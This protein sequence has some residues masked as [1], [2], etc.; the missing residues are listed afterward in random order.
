MKTGINFNQIIILSSLDKEEADTAGDLHKFIESERIENNLNFETLL[1]PFE[2]ANDLENILSNIEEN[3]RK[4]ARPIIQIECHGDISEGLE[5]TNGS[6]LSWDRLEQLL[7]PINVSTRFNLL[8]GIAACFGGHFIGKMVPTNPCPCWAVVAP[9]KEVDPGQ[10]I[11]GFRKF[12]GTLLR[13]KSINEAQNALKSAEGTWFLNNAEQWYLE[14]TKHYLN[15]YHT[16]KIMRSRVAQIH[17]KLKDEEKPQSMSFIKKELI[18][19]NR[20]DLMEV[21]FND[22]FSTKA[23][24]ENIERF[25]SLKQKIERQIDN[26]KE[27]GTHWV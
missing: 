8:V 9:A 27:N 1:K 2:S 23:I 14:I 5:L 6:T 7:L 22:Y 26:L 18:K 4:G 21:F 11:S 19:L 3:S 15:T 20:I 17:K 10:V 16:P 25:S 13:T 24:P 12:Y